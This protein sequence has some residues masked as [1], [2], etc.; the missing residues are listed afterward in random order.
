MRFAKNGDIPQ[1]EVAAVLL[2]K[3]RLA[4]FGSL[5]FTLHVS[6]GIGDDNGVKHLVSLAVHEQHHAG[7]LVGFPD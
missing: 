2:S 7:F 4:A 6:F 5:D 3:E 1:N